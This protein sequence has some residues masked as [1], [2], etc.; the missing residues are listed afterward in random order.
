MAVVLVAGAVLAVTGVVVHT[1]LMGSRHS[2]ARTRQLLTKST[3]V[4]TTTSSVLPVPQL[5]AE[6]I[7]GT[8]HEAITPAG[9][10]AR[11]LTGPFDSSRTTSISSFGERSA[12]PVK[13]KWSNCRKRFY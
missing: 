7:C 1:V 4:K 11:W 8:L 6:A 5:V 10:K 3:T 2:K 12:A 9:F 13:A